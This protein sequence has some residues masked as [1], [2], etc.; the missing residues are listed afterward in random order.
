MLS[1]N[2]VVFVDISDIVEPIVESQ[3]ND[4]SSALDTEKIKKNHNTK[5]RPPL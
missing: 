3:E 1:G 5:I 4:L 2:D